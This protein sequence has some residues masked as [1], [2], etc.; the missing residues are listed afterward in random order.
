[1]L[2]SLGLTV[3]RLPISQHISLKS[4]TILSVNHGKIESEFVENKFF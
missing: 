4:S 2:I 3:K 1:M